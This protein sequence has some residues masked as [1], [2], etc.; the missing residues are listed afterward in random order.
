MA[1]FKQEEV[2]SVAELSARRQRSLVSTVVVL[3]LA[4]IIFTLQNGRMARVGVAGST[5]QLLLSS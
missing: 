2:A 5:E 1:D 3:V 4:W